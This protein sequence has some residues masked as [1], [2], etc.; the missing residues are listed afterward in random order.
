MI[1]QKIS[2]LAQEA[3]KIK[4]APL[5]PLSASVAAGS[6]KR[7]GATHYRILES[8]AC[9]RVALVG[10]KG[11]LDASAAES[12]LWKLQSWETNH[13]LQAIL[14]QGRPGHAF[15]VGWNAGK[16]AGPEEKLASFR[17]YN[18]LSYLL[19]T[20]RKPTISWFTGD[21]VGSGMGLGLTRYRV[22][23]E[24]STFQVSEGVREGVNECV[25]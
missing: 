25:S 1:R 15:S 8:P 23:T 6:K 17:R 12:L 18:Q 3:K 14:L 16:D 4:S 11:C 20:I 24:K 22:A 9:R 21:V 19:A 10:H 5:P 7:V 2:K 13:L